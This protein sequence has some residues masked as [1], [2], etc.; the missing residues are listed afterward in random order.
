MAFAPP[1]ATTAGRRRWLFAAPG[2]P[3]TGQGPE[4]EFTSHHLLGLLNTGPEIANARVLVYYTRRAPV[5]PYRLTVAPR[6][7]RRLRLNDLIFPE[8]IR[9]EHPY[10]LAVDSDQPL[11]AHL[12]G[13][14]SLARAAARTWTLA[15]VA[16]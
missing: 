2:I 16:A 7:L 12:G 4:P 11:V 8:A 10:G 13:Q 15:F 5:G 6:R 1:P 9:L 3:A 14:H